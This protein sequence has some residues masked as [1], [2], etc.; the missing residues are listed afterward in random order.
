MIEAPS[1]PGRADISGPD[2][3]VPGSAALEMLAE[4]PEFHLD[5]E[6]APGDIQFL[7]NHTVL[8]DRTAFVDWPAPERKRHLLRLWLCP[9]NGRP[10]PERYAHFGG[11][12]TIGD[13]GGIVCPGTKPHAPLTPA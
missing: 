2:A 10:L 7:H 12:A 8:H 4:D 3:S 5:M 9:Q 1:T 13:R 6:F 11:S